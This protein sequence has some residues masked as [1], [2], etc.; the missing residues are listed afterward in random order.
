MSPVGP[1]STVGVVGTVA[2]GWGIQ[3]LR[4]LQPALTARSNGG[5]PTHG[6]PGPPIAI[7]PFT[8][9]MAEQLGAHS[10][11]TSCSHR[12][13]SPPMQNAAVHGE[14]AKRMAAAATG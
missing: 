2:R 5:T 3:L 4:I 11:S 9:E 14:V 7:K 1:P 10:G 13:I 8:H 6:Q 12:P